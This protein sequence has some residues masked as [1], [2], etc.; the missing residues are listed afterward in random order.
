MFYEATISPLRRPSAS[1][2]KKKKENKKS[3]RQ[4]LSDREP[5]R[6]AC[7][8]AGRRPAPDNPVGDLKESE[9]PS[10][11]FVGRR[12]SGFRARG[13][14][15]RDNPKNRTQTAPSAQ[16]AGGHTQPAG[17]ETESSISESGLGEQPRVERG[18]VLLR[19]NRHPTVANPPQLESQ[20]A[21]LER[22]IAPPE[23]QNNANRA[24]NAQIRIPTPYTRRRL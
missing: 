15:P 10:A 3:H 2:L 12:S 14:P 9:P 5:I 24:Q 7:P 20:I 23:R 17:K 16:R 4:R 21:Q 8:D 13:K 19:R 1:S 22:K 6:S 11:E 18:P